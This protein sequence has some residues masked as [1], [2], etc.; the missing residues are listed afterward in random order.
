MVVELVVAE[1]VEASKQPQE[2]AN[3]GGGF[4]R[5]NH[6]RKSIFINSVLFY[7]KFWYQIATTY[8]S[9]TVF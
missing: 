6:L 2:R 7:N 4:D 1:S 3:D 9:E 8:D 5:L